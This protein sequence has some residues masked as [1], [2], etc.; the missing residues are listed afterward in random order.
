MIYLTHLN[1]K[2][3]DVSLP[4]PVLFGTIDLKHVVVNYY[5]VNKTTELIV[6]QQ[7]DWLLHLTAMPDHSLTPAC[8][9][10]LNSIHDYATV[11]KD[12]STFFAVVQTSYYLM[13]WTQEKKVTDF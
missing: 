13:Q 2:W 8:T 7:P 10:E 4:H 12:N 6:K 9:A 1:H 3:Y 11:N 5:A